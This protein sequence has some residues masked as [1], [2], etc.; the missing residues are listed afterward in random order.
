MPLNLAEIGAKALIKEIRG[1]DESKKFLER[2][3]FSVGREVTVVSQID[4]NLIVGVLDTRV[5]LSRSVAGRII[6]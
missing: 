5:A 3:G 1:K 6:I 4:G 2:L